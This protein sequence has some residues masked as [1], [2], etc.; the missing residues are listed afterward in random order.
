MASSIQ[1]VELILEGLVSMASRNLQQ[2]D[3]Q[4]NFHV[5]QELGDGGFGSVLMVKEKKTDQI[6]AL[7]V[8]DRNKTTEFTFLM[9]LSMSFFVSSHPNIIETYGTAFK[10]CDYFAF[11]QEASMGGDLFSLIEPNVGLSEDK[12]KRCAVQ[13]SSALEFI[14]SKGLVHL[15]IKLENILVF[16]KDCHCIKIIDF[17]LSRV[18]GTIT[19]S[20]SGSTSYMAPE[21]RQLTDKDALLVDSTLDVWSFGIVLY[22]LLT[23]KFPW[24][25]AVS[26]DKDYSS[27]VE[28]QNNFEKINPPA[29]WSKL[30]LGALKIFSRL[31]AVDSNKRSKSTE[32]LMFLDECWR[33]QISQS[34]GGTSGNADAKECELSNCYQESYICKDVSARIP[35]NLSY[36]SISTT[37]MSYYLTSDSSDSESEETLD[38]WQKNVLNPSMIMDDK[39]SVHV[40]ADVELG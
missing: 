18:K 26:T 35:S 14:H 24:Q 11:T 22:S 4:E 40:E 34:T 12:V 27:F 2:I 10:T 38:N 37:S 31:L 6:M 25:S 20:K 29:P 15:D 5:I 16:H 9:E 3:L 28:W 21:M 39:I 19:R 7:K 13:I 32:V 33:E 17:G 8:L 30:A 23:G 36:S 1:I